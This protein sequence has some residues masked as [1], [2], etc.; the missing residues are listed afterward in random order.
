MGIGKEL[1]ARAEVAKD[2]SARQ[3]SD[4]WSLV[5]SAPGFMGGM[6]K[7]YWL[8]AKRTNRAAPSEADL[9]I[10]RN[11]VRD[12]GGPGSEKPEEAVL[13]TLMWRWRGDVKVQIPEFEVPEASPAVTG[14]PE[15]P[16]RND[17]C[18]CGSGKKYKKCCLGKE[19]SH[20][21]CNGP[22][23]PGSRGE[24]DDRCGKDSC[25]SVVC[26][27]CAKKYAHCHEHR[28][29]IHTMMNGH[30]LRV[31]PEL[32]PPSQFDKLLKDDV[33]MDLLRKQAAKSPE[34]WA[35]LF[36]YIDERKRAGN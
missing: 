13:G 25:G 21:P 1:R 20:G 32:I 10:L 27:S 33:Q 7:E 35:R 19:I 23:M 24:V 17:P 9:V 16:D 22:P 2:K 28:G 30:V 29:V 36:E 15:K 31:H 4:G 5:M 18:P 26:K 34:L 14:Q 6:I 3:D 12:A 11:I 8:T